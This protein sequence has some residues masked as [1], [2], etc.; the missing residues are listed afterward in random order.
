MEKQEI[1]RTKRMPKLTCQTKDIFR[2]CYRIKGSLE[3][4]QEVCVCVWV[5]LAL[6]CKGKTVIVLILRNQAAEMSGR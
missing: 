5:I 4:T 6:T 2:K 1:Q 3:R